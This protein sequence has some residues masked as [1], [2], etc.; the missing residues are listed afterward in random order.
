MHILL[1]IALVVLLVATVVFF[2]MALLRRSANTMGASSATAHPLWGEHT[3]TIQSGV[4]WFLSKKPEVVEVSS[5]DKLRLH[6]YFL[7]SAGAKT[8]IILM[9]GYRSKNLYDFSC[10]YRHYH[11]LGYNLLVPWQRSHGLSE[12]KLICFGVKER[13]DCLAWVKY[14]I[15]RFGEDEDIILEGMSMGAT[16]VLLAAGLPLPEN[17]RAIIADSGFISPYEVMEHT[18]RRWR[19]LPHP[20]LDLMVPIT[21]LFGIDLRVN[22][23]DA[24]KKC[25][26]PLLLIHG[27]ADRVVPHEMARRN[28]EAASG[29]KELLIVPGAHHGM[30]YLIDSAA[31]ENAIDKFLKNNC[32]QKE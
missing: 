13:F 21:R 6:G 28:Y 8:T 24:L 12:G 4:D 5:S 14:I 22:T 10:V 25:K 19:I 17:V 3:E 9:H 30:S 23:V 27:D 20:Y 16:T 11:E 31:C 1:I 32:K 26:L 29:E 18:M 2:N 7:P 15:K